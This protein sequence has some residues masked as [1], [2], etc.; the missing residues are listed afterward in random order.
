MTFRHLGEGEMGMKRMR[1]TAAWALFLMALYLALAFTTYDPWPASFGTPRPTNLGGGFGLWLSRRFVEPFGVGAYVLCFFLVFIGG[2]IQARRPIRLHALKLLGLVLAMFT[3]GAFCQAALPSRHFPSG[4]L[5]LGGI[6]G[7]VVVLRLDSLL[8]RTW[9]LVLM[10]L[11]VFGSLLLLTEHLLPDLLTRKSGQQESAKPATSA[12]RKSRKKAA[13]AEEVG[14][15]QEAPAEEETPPNAPRRRADRKPAPV[16]EGAEV[17]EPVLDDLAAVATAPSVRDRRKKKRIQEELDELPDLLEDE[18]LAEPEE[19]LDPE[20]ESRVEEEP[21]ELEETEESLVPAQA[22]PPQIRAAAAPM[23]RDGIEVIRLAPDPKLKGKEKYELPPLSLLTE[24]QYLEDRESDEVIQAKAI[25]LEQALLDY[26]VTAKVEE[27][28]RGPVITRYDISIARGTK[29][30]KVTSLADE[31]AMSLGVQRVR[32]APVKGRPVLGV[33][34]PNR[35]RETVFLKEIVLA[36]DLRKRK[37][38]I[39]LFLGKDAAGNPVVEDLATTP[40]L[41]IAGRTG[42]GKSVFVNDL[43]CS[44]LLTRYPEEVRLVMI[45]PKKVELEVYQDIP[46]LYTKVESN[47]KKATKILEWAVNQMEERYELLA[48]AGVR[49]MRDYNKM[50]AKARAVRL[51]KT[52]SPGEIEKLPEHLPYI[53]IIVD[54]FADL[55][56]VAGKEVEQSIAR[57]AQKARAVGIHVV[58]ATQ[59]PSTDVITG[60]IKSN[61]P[62]RIAFQTRVGVDS[63]TILDRYG[64]EKLLDKGDMLYLSATSDD[65]KRIQGPFVSDEE[66]EKIVAYLREKASPMYTHHLEQVTAST[67][68]EY[69]IAER[70]ELFEAAVECVL[71]SGQASA[72]HL[73]TRMNVGYARARRL[74]EMMGEAGFVGAAQGAKPREILLTPEKWEEIRAKWTKQPKKTADELVASSSGDE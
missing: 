41:L 21:E 2:L 72:S 12:K 74:V 22:N 50:P 73:Q 35:E 63:R 29:I 31:I 55:M 59:R 38:A 52:Y 4:N 40:H 14:T 28:E 39:P 16:A 10:G 26:G 65:P 69:A 45:D 62:A 49:H 53:V 70:D 64:A 61:L 68:P 6:I 71:N 5:T 17:D 15:N 54:E 42:A 67:T 34:I 33:E 60:L 32:I 27:I 44:I 47:S 8:G 25:A 20:S 24:P 66:V 57:L 37:I 3:F 1:Q 19:E 7:D 23:L 18:A 58:L 36:A 11:G 9:T 13:A 51:E 56:M 46:H 48:A 30:T 43:I